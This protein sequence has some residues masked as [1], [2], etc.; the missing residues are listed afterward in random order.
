M[1]AAMS[2]S[3]NKVLQPDSPMQLAGVDWI[4]PELLYCVSPAAR[5]NSML[6]AAAIPK[7]YIRSPAIG[8]PAGCRAA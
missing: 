4:N 3:A 6:A 7:K 5:F 1:G 8:I 2:L